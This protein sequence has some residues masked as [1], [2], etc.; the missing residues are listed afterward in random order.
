VAVLPDRG[1]VD[2]VGVPGRPVVRAE[3]RAPA[4][5]VAG[6][7]SRPRCAAAMRG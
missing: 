2:L 4:L 6:A 5:H 3:R 1:I 7:A